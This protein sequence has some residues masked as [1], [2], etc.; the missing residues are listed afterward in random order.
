MKFFWEFNDDGEYEEEDITYFMDVGNKY[1]VATV[2]HLD[3]TPLE[4]GRILAE[5]LSIQ[6]GVPIRLDAECVVNRRNGMS[7][8]PTPKSVAV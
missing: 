8:L 6:A 2:T 1:R 4:M 3:A 5:A 7:S